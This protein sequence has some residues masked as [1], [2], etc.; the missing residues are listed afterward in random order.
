MSDYEVVSTTTKGL[1]ASVEREV[2]EAAHDEWLSNLYK[3]RET[4]ICGPAQNEKT[5]SGLTQ[6][7]FALPYDLIDEII[8]KFNP[9]VP[10]N[11]AWF[12]ERFEYY[13]T[14]MPY[15]EFMLPIVDI[16][17][18]DETVFNDWMGR[19]VDR[20]PKMNSSWFKTATMLMKEFG[21]SE[22]LGTDEDISTSLTQLRNL[23]DQCA[24]ID[25][26][27]DSKIETDYILR[28]DNVALRKMVI[29]AH[30]Y[31]RVSSFQVPEMS[32]FS[33]E[34]QI[35]EEQINE[36]LA[37]LKAQSLAD[38]ENAGIDSQYIINNFAKDASLTSFETF[39]RMLALGRYRNEQQGIT[40][41][42]SLDSNIKVVEVI[43]NEYTKLLYKKGRMQKK[44]L[45]VL[46]EELDI[47]AEAEGV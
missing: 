44:Y 37:L 7:Q 10:I 13:H 8:E 33:G 30:H 21:I 6:K 43:L 12:Q 14:T 25:Q 39:V 20:A 4:H 19:I 2:T 45:S 9:N 29:A 22:E 40:N 41:A 11:K 24:F 35:T 5:E 42:I 28:A 34:M 18:M 32:D 27:Q 23:Y 15:S 17:V 36:Q 31:W 16:K 47:L 1:M 38:I 46:T 3:S 26:V